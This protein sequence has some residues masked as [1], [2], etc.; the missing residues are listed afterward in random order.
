MSATDQMRQSQM[1]NVAGHDV[2]V[3]NLD[4]VLFPLTGFTKRDLI[5]YYLAVADGALRGAGGRPNMLVRYPNGIGQ[6]HFYQKRAP[7]G[8]PDWIEVAQLRFPS[9]RTASDAPRDG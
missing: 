9:G 8:R 3:S 4:K 5:H 1:L 6:E 7:Q 2:A